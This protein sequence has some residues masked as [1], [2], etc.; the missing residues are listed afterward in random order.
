MGAP[1]FKFRQ[2][3]VWHDRCA[4]KVGTDGV[5]LGAWAGQ[6]RLGK[7][8]ENPPRNILDIGTGSGLIAL[9]LAQRFPKARITGIDCDRD[10]AMQAKENFTGSPWADR[11]RTVHIG[12]QGFCRDTVTAAERFDLIVSNPPFY[13]NTLTNPDSRR[14]TARHTGGLPHDE[15]LL[16][17]AGLLTDSGVFSLIV[18]S[19]SEKSIL[20]LAD[21]SRL[22]LHRLTRVYSRPGS[23]VR[24]I[25]ASFGKS[26][27]PAPIEDSLV[28]TDADGHRSAEHAA[29]TKEFY[30]Y[31]Q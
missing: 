5:L 9:M 18:P 17:S 2:F 31:E 1:F 23:G 11:L 6:E 26:P 28:L 7:T 25:L 3:T 22:H 14:S 19:E 29:L 21:R 15:L 13:D 8:Q 4:M 30:L 16:L 12:L 10:A 24:R 27:V 20:R